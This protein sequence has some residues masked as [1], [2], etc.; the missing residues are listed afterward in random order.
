[1]W[2]RTPER[3]SLRTSGLLKITGVRNGHLC[4]MSVKKNKDEKGRSR[5]DTQT[6]RIFNDRVTLSFRKGNNIYNKNLNST[7][8]TSYG[9]CSHPL[10][11]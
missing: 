3:L 7:P 8:K 6:L 10:T 4:P 2:F 11:K 5:L 1:M 9:S